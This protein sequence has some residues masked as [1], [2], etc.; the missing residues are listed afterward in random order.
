MTTDVAD[1]AKFEDKILQLIAQAVPSKFR[2]ARITKD[3]FLRKDL[4]ID[5][6]GMVALVFRIEELFGVDLSELGASVSLN[7]LR[8]VGDAIDVSRDSVR[9]ASNGGT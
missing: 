3:M 6:L 5:S 7:Q 4:G 8:T 9:R 1:D 2:K